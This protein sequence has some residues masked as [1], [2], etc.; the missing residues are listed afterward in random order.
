MIEA[1]DL[2][3]NLARIRS[4]S[5]I[6]GVLGQA[7]KSGQKKR[8]EAAKTGQVTW[9][10]DDE[11]KEWVKDDEKLLA[12]VLAENRAKYQAASEEGSLV[13]G[14]VDIQKDEAVL[15]SSAEKLKL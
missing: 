14:E 12:K 10:T 9:S 7:G 6:S 8:L 3:A 15:E 1:Q 4:I 13:E 2:F 11:F 5:L